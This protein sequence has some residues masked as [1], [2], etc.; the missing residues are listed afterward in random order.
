[1]GT[2]KTLRIGAGT[3]L[4]KSRFARVSQPSILSGPCGDVC[5]R[6]SC[7]WRADACPSWSC[8]RCCSHA[9]FANARPFAISPTLC[10]GFRCTLCDAPAKRESRLDS[11]QRTHFIF[12]VADDPDTL[13]SESCHWSQTYE[14]ES[15]L[16]LTLIRFSPIIRT[17]CGVMDSVTCSSH[18]PRYIFQACHDDAGNLALG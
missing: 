9:P 11:S 14:F 4:A 16:C 10:R 13:G 15:K 7:R 17:F 1:M 12:G 18:F 8:R 6:R 5:R 2:G 3:S